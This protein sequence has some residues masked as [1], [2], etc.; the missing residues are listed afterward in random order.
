MTV[1]G[2]L[3]LLKKWVTELVFLEIVMELKL[4]VSFM[5]ISKALSVKQSFFAEASFPSQG[6]A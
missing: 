6:N 2:I 3:Y 1:M 5:Y 4:T